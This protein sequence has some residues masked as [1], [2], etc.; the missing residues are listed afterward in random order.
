MRFRLA[1]NSLGRRVE[2]VL[3]IER[4]ERDSDIPSQNKDRTAFGINAVVGF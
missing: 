2:Y 1:E 4:Y 3:R